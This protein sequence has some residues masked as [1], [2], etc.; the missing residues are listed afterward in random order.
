VV[1]PAQAGRA[2]ASGQGSGWSWQ[3]PFFF[4]SHAE[5]KR[6]KKEIGMK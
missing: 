5:K 6:N 2:V 1:P 3:G 4:F